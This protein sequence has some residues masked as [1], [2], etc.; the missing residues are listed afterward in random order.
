MA[1]GVWTVTAIG[2]FSSRVAC[3]DDKTKIW[4][5]LVEVAPDIPA[6]VK[7]P[8]DQENLQALISKWVDNG[9]SWV[10]LDSHSLVV[11]FILTEPAAAI[12]LR[13]KNKALYLPYIGVSKRWQGR[14]VFPRLLDNLKSQG[15][16]L[17]VSVLH[18]NKRDMVGKLEKAGFAKDSRQ[19]PNQT[20]LRWNP[21][22]AAQANKA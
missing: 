4:D 3:S 19:E 1:P 9:N 15:E 16:P 5:V 20:Y 18:M 2:A 14:G 17:T 12:R 22:N 11:G 13:E 6:R 21:S 7:D 8:E 10:A